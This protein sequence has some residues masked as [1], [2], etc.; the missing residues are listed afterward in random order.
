MV[1]CLKHIMFQAQ[2]SRL[3][4]LHTFLNA[5]WSHHQLHYD[6][7]ILWAASS[8]VFPKRGSLQPRALL[9][10]PDVCAGRVLCLVRRAQNLQILR[11]QVFGTGTIIFTVLAEETSVYPALTCW[12]CSLCIPCTLCCM[13]LCALT[14]STTRKHELPITTPSAMSHLSVDSQPTTVLSL[15]LYHI[16]LFLVLQI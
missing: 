2:L 12:R 11:A 1:P 9:P 7:I 15:M 3:P 5:V 6:W 4:I 8:F 16:H 14:D 10:C 13:R